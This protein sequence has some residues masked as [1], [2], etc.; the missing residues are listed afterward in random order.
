MSA[1]VTP[2]STWGAQPGRIVPETVETRRLAVPA[3]GRWAAEAFVAE[4]LA[5]LTDRRSVDQPASSSVYR[6]GQ[7][8]ADAALVAFDVTGYAGRKD[9]AYPQPRRSVSGLSPWVRHGLLDLPRLWDHVE[10]GPDLDVRA[11]RGELLWQEYAR[12]R[13]ARRRTT[14]AARPAAAVAQR[15]AT[16]RGW[17][18]RMGCVEIAIDE[19]DEDGWLVDRAR[20]WLAAHWITASGEDPAEGEDHFFRHLLDG[21]RAANGLGWAHA[22]H[23]DLS[24]WDVEERAPGLCASCEL[25]RQCPIERPRQPEAE[26]AA[27]VPAIAPDPAA[28]DGSAEADPDLAA[29][30]GP[31]VTVGTASDADAVWLTAESLGD[32]DPALSAHPDLP[33]VF[34]FDEPLL[35]GLRLSSKRLVF[36]TETLAEL[37]AS[38][39]V[40]LYL[41]DPV[42][43]LSG[44]SLAATFT[45]VPGWRRRSA[46]LTMT[47]VHPWP[48]LREPLDGDLTTFDNWRSR[49]R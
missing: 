3:P 2:S 48:W 37:A 6:G 34:V 28:L 32:G 14:P 29:T 43:A 25:V 21:S 39:A 46:Q 24:R 22:R 5:H 36:L 19:L 47:V 30:A 15:A 12:H 9:E 8:A 31:R 17:D 23:Y 11:F 35:A 27:V 41:G 40:E 20:R 4:Q 10:G 1:Q 45:P 38:R 49:Y 7:G 42:E 26:L 13:Y 16:G 33:A 44:R 18:R